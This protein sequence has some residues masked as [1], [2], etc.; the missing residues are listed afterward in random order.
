MSHSLARIWV[1]IVFG[2]KFRQPLLKREFRG[3][4]YAHLRQ[5]FAQ[6]KCRVLIINGT[7][8]HVHAL[9]MLPRNLSLATLMQSIK[10]ESSH[11][12]NRCSFLPSPFSWQVGY[13]AFSVSESIVPT[14]QAYIQRQEKHHR[15]MD[16]EEELG[17]LESGR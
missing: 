9:A 16:Y 6:L 2:T 11:W 12:I 3:A 1:H 5:T 10:G 4:L 17:R 13:G 7:A 14:V 15:A 8:D